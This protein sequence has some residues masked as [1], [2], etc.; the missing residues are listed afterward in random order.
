MG[1]SLGRTQLA[2]LDINAYLPDKL[3]FIP[4]PDAM[5]INDNKN[6]KLTKFTGFEIIN[7]AVFIV[8]QIK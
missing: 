1:S 5:V 6:Y 7:N 3:C 8:S 2:I 4:S